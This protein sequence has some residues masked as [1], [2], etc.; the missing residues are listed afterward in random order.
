MDEPD[1]G[2]VKD[3]NAKT[4]LDQTID[5]E[6]HVILKSN[7]QERM[8]ENEN[9]PMKLFSPTSLREENIKILAENL[10]QIIISNSLQVCR[11]KRFEKKLDSTSEKSKNQDS[12][13]IVAEKFENLTNKITDVIS[14]AYN[15]DNLNDLRKSHPLP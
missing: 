8:L 12:N 5:D 10:T 3:A 7:E 4:N 14:D 6:H 2:Q 1:L 15:G 9:A 11:E 13:P